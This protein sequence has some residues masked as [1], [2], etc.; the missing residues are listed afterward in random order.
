MF[1]GP[2]RPV[3][4]HLDVQRHGHPHG[5]VERGEVDQLC[6]V[7]LPG[8]CLPRWHTPQH[9][10]AVRGRLLWRS[11]QHGHLLAVSFLPR[12][13]G[14]VLTADE[15]AVDVEP[16]R[17]V[18]G[19]IHLALASLAELCA[20]PRN[21]DYVCRVSKRPQR[22]T[23]TRESPYVCARM[24]LECHS[25]AAVRW[26]ATPSRPKA[27]SAPTAPP[28]PPALTGRQVAD[29]WSPGQRGREDG[30]R[31]CAGQRRRECRR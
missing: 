29:N 26:N 6:R 23:T 19:H 24:P 12:P 16:D 30:L 18:R 5:A 9:K 8:Q 17:V 15:L 13:Y 25:A 3:C 7:D 14:P 21:V 4:A 20:C 10:K 22:A 27:G 28:W 31:A 2:G 11:W 1:A